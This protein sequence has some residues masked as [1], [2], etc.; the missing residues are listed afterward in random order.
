MNLSE[1]RIECQV[2]SSIDL[3]RYPIHH[4][5]SE[6]CVSLIERC[7]EQ[8]RKKGVCI[9]EGFLTPDA[10]KTFIREAYE[11]MPLTYHSRV[12]G[13]A[14]LQPND[15]TLPSQH[16][17]NLQEETAL[18]VIA[19]DQIPKWQGIRQ[20]YET[21]QVMEFI[22]KVLGKEK[23]FR[24]ADPMGALNL[25]VMN[26]GDYLRWHFDQTDFVVSI[27]LQDSEIGGDFEYV[28]FIRTQENQNYSTV[29]EVLRG[30]S[31]AIER[32]P[33]CPGTLVLFE[34]RNSIH[35]VTR[36]QGGVPR[37]VALLGYDTRP[38][39]MSTDHLRFMRY[40]RTI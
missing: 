12:V 22:A 31:F 1:N 8:L 20:L 33:M 28:P 36:I 23:I 13:N 7:Q 29:E 27:A 25:S 40:G 38:D 11:L 14:Y 24:Y 35:R 34:G 2:A 4:L 37:L 16:P 26:Q 3:D 39:V 19:Y 6:K 10:L 32:L 15:V 5:R 17:R 9:L 18:G 30:S 21:E